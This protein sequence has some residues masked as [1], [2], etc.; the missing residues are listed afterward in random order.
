[1]C[2]KAV[3]QPVDDLNVVSEVITRNAQA[4]MGDAP[5]RCRQSNRRARALRAHAETC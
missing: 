1:M 4:L 5:P 3:V 2:S